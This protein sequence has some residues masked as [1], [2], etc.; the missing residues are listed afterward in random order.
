MSSHAGPSSN[1]ASVDMSNLMAIAFSWARVSGADGSIRGFAHKLK[2]RR[3]VTGRNTGFYRLELCFGGGRGST[4]RTRRGVGCWIGP[5]VSFWFRPEG[6]DPNSNQRGRHKEN[7]YQ[8]LPFSHHVP[9]HETK[10]L[11]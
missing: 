11:V 5:G 9:A 1:R 8:A 3:R 6:Q 10:F 7:Y 2:D 4:A